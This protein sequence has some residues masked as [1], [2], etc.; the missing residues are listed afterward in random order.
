LNL[1]KYMVALCASLILMGCA[2]TSYNTARSNANLVKNGMTVQQAVELIGT[3]PTE[4][5]TTALEWR[6]GNT[7]SYDATPG[8]AISFHVRDGV[9]V[10]V[11]MGGIFGVEARRLFIQA[12]A[13]QRDSQAARD[14]AQSEQDA[15]AAAEARARRDAE[16]AAKAEKTRAE[17][18]AEA[19]QAQAEIKAESEA[20]AS[21]NVTCNVKSTCAKVFALAQIYIAT[22]T[23]QKIQVVTD[24]VIQT[25]NPTE[26]GNVGASIIKMPQRGDGALVSLS[27]SCKSS[28]SGA[29]SSLCRGKNTR[30][31]KGFRPFIESRLAQ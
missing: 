30:L 13:A 14:S 26:G 18:A 22:E 21:A 27:L 8:G 29:L 6:R 9:I 11:P 1:K 2:A 5:T 28:G 25:Y 24:S 12:W 31:Y 17:Q 16:Q 10:D 15:R 19:A 7:Q 20:A 3:L 23:D 4:Q